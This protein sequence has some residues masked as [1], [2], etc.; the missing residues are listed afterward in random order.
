MPQQKKIVP[1][2]TRSSTCSIDVI[3]FHG[4]A[5]RERVATSSSMQ[6]VGASVAGLPEKNLYSPTSLDIFSSNLHCNASSLHLL[7]STW[8]LC[9]DFNMSDLTASVFQTKNGFH[10]DGYE[11]ISYDFTFLDGVFDTKNR[12]LAECYQRWG[13]VLAVTDMNVYNM[14]GEQMEKYFEHYNLD[15]KVHK[16][17]IGE[18]AKTIPTFLS[19][20][21]S[22]T[23]FGIYRKVL[24]TFLW[25]VRSFWVTTVFIDVNRN[26]YWL[27]VE[28]L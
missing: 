20:V 15:L 8:S 6:R 13:R 2:A 21:D 28:D 14:Y 25:R 18:K 7:L 4:L 1:L 12:Q 3:D 11:K 19:I 23:E 5:N 17:K 22:M 24:A 16:T 10:V 9:F 26:L 27:L